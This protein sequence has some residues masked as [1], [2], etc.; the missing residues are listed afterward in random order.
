MK[1]QLQH[2][3]QLEMQTHHPH[4]GPAEFDALGRGPGLCVFMNPP[5]EVLH[6]QMWGPLCQSG[7]LL[8][9]TQVPIELAAILSC[10]P[11]CPG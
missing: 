5:R 6:T 9:L 10:D 11:K 3:P 1:P 8:I 2:H 4:S 7:D